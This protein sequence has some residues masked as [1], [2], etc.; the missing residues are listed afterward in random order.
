MKRFSVPGVFSK[1][2]Y[3][4]DGAFLLTYKSV[5]AAHRLFYMVWRAGK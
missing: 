2:L 3:T 5:N 4:G 1:N